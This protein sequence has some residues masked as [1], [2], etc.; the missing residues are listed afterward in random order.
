MATDGLTR[1]L[2]EHQQALTREFEALK[3]RN[4]EIPREVEAL[5]QETA[6]NV[7]RLHELRGAFEALTKV[8]ATIIPAPAAVVE[9]TATS[10]THRSRRATA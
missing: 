9:R 3:A 5:Q 4:A 7:I 8:Q 10:K 6:R 1:L 2:A